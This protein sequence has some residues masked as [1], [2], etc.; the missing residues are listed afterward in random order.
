[1]IMLFK[2]GITFKTKD[3]HL[4]FCYKFCTTIYNA[5]CCNEY[6]CRKAFETSPDYL[7]KV[8]ELELMHQRLHFF[9]A[10]GKYF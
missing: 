9:D 8:L 3:K 4:D 1:M 10:F 5:D 6:P 7:L 2:V